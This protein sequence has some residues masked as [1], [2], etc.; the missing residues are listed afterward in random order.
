MIICIYA[1]NLMIYISIHTH[2]HTHTH[3]TT[4][5]HTH[6]H[7]YLNTHA[8]ICTG[9]GIRERY[10]STDEDTVKIVLKFLELVKTSD[11]VQL[12]KVSG[13]RTNTFA[14]ESMRQRC[15]DV[16]LQ[17]PALA[18]NNLP[19]LRAKLRSTVPDAP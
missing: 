11:W 9:L 10:K 3:M 4:H 19:A 12:E 14:L 2:T 17:C 1:Y 5:T 15:T 13:I 16:A 7:E 18:A 8:Y 6:T